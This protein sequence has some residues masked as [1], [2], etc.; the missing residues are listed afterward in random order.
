VVDACDLVDADRRRRGDELMQ[1]IRRDERIVVEEPVLGAQQL[2]G[3]TNAV[4]CGARG[5]SRI[6]SLLSA[7]TAAAEAA[8]RA[9][10]PSSTMS[11]R[12]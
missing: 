10:C 7:R 9:P 8:Q 5:S 3:G 6:M 2:R 11:Q 1:R 12:A 4:E